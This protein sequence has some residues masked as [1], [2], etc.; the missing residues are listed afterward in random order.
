[1]NNSGKLAHTLS[2]ADLQKFLLMIIG[3]SPLKCCEK[4]TTPEKTALALKPG[5]GEAG[6]GHLG[7]DGSRHERG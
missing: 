3:I 2:A 7:G 6:G 4:T 5:S 1:M